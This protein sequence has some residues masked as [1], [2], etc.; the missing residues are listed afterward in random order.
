MNLVTASG[1]P[2]NI[3]K[4]AQ[5]TDI[6][7]NTLGREIMPRHSPASRAR[8][9]SSGLRR[10]CDG[11]GDPELNCRKYGDKW[12]CASCEYRHNNPVHVRSGLTRE[13]SEIHQ[14]MKLNG[15]DRQPYGR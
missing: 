13:Q 12:L 5:L 7:G 1:V 11:C 15:D 9:G 2:Y 6:G 8:P 3:K 4:G 10:I 14:L